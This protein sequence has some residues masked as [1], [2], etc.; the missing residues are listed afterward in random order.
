MKVIPTTYK[1]YRFRSRLEARWAVFFSALNTPWEYERE[2]FDLRAAGRYLPDFWLPEAGLWL[3]IKGQAPSDTE[4]QKVAALASAQPDNN[5]LMAI[6]VPGEERL[7]ILSEHLR[8]EEIFQRTTPMELWG[9]AFGLFN[10]H[11]ERAYAAARAARFE[12]GET[13]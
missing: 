5:V 11:I 12:H 13:P 7:L 3:E 10:P 1:G 6:G 8:R 2:G 4:Y 9:A